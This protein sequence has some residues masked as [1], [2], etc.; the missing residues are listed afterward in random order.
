MSTSFDYDVF[1]SHSSKDKRIIRKLADKLTGDGVRVWLD[2][3]IIPPGDSIPLAI[4]NGLVKSRVL[5]ICWSK[6]YAESEWGQFEANTFL[7]RDPNNRVRRFVPLRLDDH[8]M[9]APRSKYL[10]IDYRKKG[11][12][13]YERRR[14]P[15]RPREAAARRTGVEMTRAEADSE[16]EPIFSLGHTDSVQSVAF[17]PEGQQ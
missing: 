10:Y 2:E 6:N 4:K 5:A 13:E 1:L 15:R 7:F 11:K 17:S 8:E 14:D 16:A 3:R 12:K 9:E